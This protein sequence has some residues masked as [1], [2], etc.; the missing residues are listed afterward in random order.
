MTEVRLTAERAPGIAD[1]SRSKSVS[2]IARFN[3]YDVA[4]AVLIAAL[5]VIALLHLQGLRD[6]QR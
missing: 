4:T 6:L 2:G 1:P 3:V 5:I